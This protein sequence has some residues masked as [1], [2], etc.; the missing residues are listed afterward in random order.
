MNHAAKVSAIM[1]E[2]CLTLNEPLK[3]QFLNLDRKIDQEITSS[4]DSVLSDIKELMNCV[5]NKMT[6]KKRL[7]I[8]DI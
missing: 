3:I 6:V 7:F 1:S 2:K 5:E 4:N 8:K